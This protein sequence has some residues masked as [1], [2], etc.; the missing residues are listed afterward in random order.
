MP[1]AWSGRLR[2]PACNQPSTCRLF[3][4]P[5]FTTLGTCGLQV[6]VDFSDIDEV[7]SKGSTLQGSSHVPHA[8][9][10]GPGKSPWRTKSRSHAR[11]PGLLL[12]GWTDSGVTSPTS[13]LATAGQVAAGS[14]APTAPIGQTF[15]I[16][17]KSDSSDALAGQENQP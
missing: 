16:Q 17:S 3:P 15:S 4:G 6:A 10:K 9:L 8:A 13:T 2:L 11:C 5:L 7:A 14:C 1:L 12:W